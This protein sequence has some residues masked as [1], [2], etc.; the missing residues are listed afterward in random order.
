MFY[1]IA[2]FFQLSAHQDDKIIVAAL[3]S[4]YYCIDIDLQVIKL[5]ARS[6][7]ETAKHFK[8]S[9]TFFL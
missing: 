2:I 6:G 4:V 7:K 3:I 9:Q 8:T 1:I 5:P